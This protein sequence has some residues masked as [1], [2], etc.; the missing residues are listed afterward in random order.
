MMAEFTRE[1]K[2]YMCDN[3]ARNTEDEPEL[4]FHCLVENG[5]T[6]DFCS[7]DCAEEHD[8][9]RTEKREME[10]EHGSLQPTDVR[11]CV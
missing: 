1:I 5:A 11:W 9:L 4:K 10:V 8:N 6:K 7:E 3:C 2:H